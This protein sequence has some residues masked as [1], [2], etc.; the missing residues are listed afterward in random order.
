MIR[1]KGIWRGSAENLAGDRPSLL[2]ERKGSSVGHSAWILTRVV[3]TGSLTVPGDQEPFNRSIWRI[4][5]GLLRLLVV[6]RFS[7]RRFPKTVRDFDWKL[8]ATVDRIEPVADVA[9]HLVFALR[10]L[11]ES[12]WFM[13]KLLSRCTRCY[14]VAGKKWHPIPCTHFCC[15]MAENTASMCHSLCSGVYTGRGLCFP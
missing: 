2:A 11:R 14:A 15:A 6:S 5:C 9:G 7:G 13:L 10:R 12:F 8:A 4:R 3:Q 1:Q